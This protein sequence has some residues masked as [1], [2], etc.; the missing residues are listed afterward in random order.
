M[1]FFDSYK[2][3]QR[4]KHNLKAFY[5]AQSDEKLKSPLS[6]VGNI[7]A[8][9][10]SV[11]DFMMKS[12]LIFEKFNNHY[13]STRIFYHSLIYCSGSNK[14]FR[15]YESEFSRLFSPIK[16]SFPSLVCLFH[17]VVISS[18]TCDQ[19]KNLQNHFFRTTF[20]HLSR[21]VDAD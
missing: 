2:F 15:K 17:I 1:V 9:K 18:K 11:R 20:L 10:L 6:S 12:G 21:K 7:F 4:F 19:L 5:P 8:L 3:F 13:E 14:Q 16:T